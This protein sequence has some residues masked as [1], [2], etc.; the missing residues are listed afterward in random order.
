MSTDLYMLTD[1]SPGFADTWEALER[2]LDE[3]KQA[4][5]RHAEHVC[6][7]CVMTCMQQLSRFYVDASGSAVR[8]AKEWAQQFYSPI[9]KKPTDPDSKS[10][11]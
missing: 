3:V 6:N 1:T 11:Q 5:K 4:G 7:A 10:P 9:P 2:R 8:A